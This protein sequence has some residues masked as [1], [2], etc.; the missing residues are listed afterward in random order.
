MVLMEAHLN[1]RQQFIH[2]RRHCPEAVG[3]CN[4]FF[5][6]ILQAFGVLVGWAV[7][8]NKPN[9]AW[10]LLWPGTIRGT[11]PW[12][13]GT[14]LGK[15]VDQL[16]NV[17]SRHNHNH[18]HKTSATTSCQPKQPKQP[19]HRRG[20]IETLP[21]SLGT[22]PRGTNSKKQLG[23]QPQQQKQPQQNWSSKLGTSKG[24]NCG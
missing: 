21:Q 10:P 6:A 24:T 12:E 4:H 19:I 16:K 1:G 23:W 2:P 8:Q 17:R 3:S 11:S 13:L 22:L 20:T 14:L 7:Y 5:F 9:F 15:L 18:N